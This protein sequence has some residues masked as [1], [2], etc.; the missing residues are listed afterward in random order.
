M[1]ILTV[2]QK[3]KAAGFDPGPLDGQWGPRTAFAL[4]SALARAALT[5]APDSV[6]PLLIAEL[7]RDEGR[8]AHAYNDHLGYV[9]VGV[10]RLLDRRKGGKLS[11][12]E[13]DMLL[14]ND[15]RRAIADVETLPAWQAVKNDP[16]RARALVNLRFQLGAAGLRGFKNSLSLIADRRWTE[17]ARNLEKSLWYRQTPARAKRVVHMIETGEAPR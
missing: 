6:D 10:G 16:V 5:A 14:A 2:Q 8:I 15:I 11:D 4:D 7:S 17:A 1:S 9:T 13:I 3:L 12:D